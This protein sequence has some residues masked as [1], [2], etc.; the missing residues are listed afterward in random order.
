MCIRDRFF[1]TATIEAKATEKWKTHPIG[2]EVRPE[3]WGCCH[4]EKSCTPKGQSFTECRDTVHATWMME[5][6]LFEKQP[7]PERKKRALED[8]RKMGYE[9]FVESASMVDLKDGQHNVKI[10]V[11]NTGIAPFYHSGWPI[12][13][14]DGKN[15]SSK[16]ARTKWELTKI[17]PDQSKTFEMKVSFDASAGFEIRVPNPMKKGKPLRFANQRQQT[18]GWLKISK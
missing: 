16:P 3:V 2:G 15:Q 9:F 1:H 8:S 14:R 5:S 4:D 12:E 17:L 6:G 13:L 18:D 11:K 7:S 10:V